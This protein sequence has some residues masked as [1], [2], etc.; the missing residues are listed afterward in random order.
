MYAIRLY[1]LLIS[2]RSVGKT[3]VFLISEF[4]ERLGVEEGEYPRM[5]DFKRWVLDAAIS[6]INQHTDI[7][8]EYDQHKSGRSITGFSFSFSAKNLERDPNTVDLLTGHADAET[9]KPQRQIITK[10]KAEG[11]A[12]PGESYEDL[13]R[14]LSRD[15]IIKAA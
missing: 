2:W 9:G 14:R 8:A 1:E 12:R 4:R 6:Q 15:Y 13:Y 5:T 7:T 11:M 3:P 10:K